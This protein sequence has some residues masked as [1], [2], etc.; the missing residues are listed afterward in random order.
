MF[1]CNVYRVNLMNRI[2]RHDEDAK[3]K[4]VDVE[5]QKAMAE[6]RDWKYVESG[7]FSREQLVSDSRHPM[8]VDM[9]M[10]SALVRNDSVEVGQDTPEPYWRDEVTKLYRHGYRES[11]ANRSECLEQVNFALDMKY[12]D[13]DV[14]RDASGRRVFVDTFQF[15]RLVFV[16]LHRANLT[17][18]LRYLRLCRSRYAQVGLQVDVSVRQI[19]LFIADTHDET[20]VD[21]RSFFREVTQ[22]VRKNGIKNA[23]DWWMTKRKNHK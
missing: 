15:D 18:T 2:D 1:W 8:Y 23:T 20:P 4:Y 22:H 17:E 21:W 19:R 7:R 16:R 10:P 11:H 13:A 14:R 3:N 9:I 5:L 6:G 12:P